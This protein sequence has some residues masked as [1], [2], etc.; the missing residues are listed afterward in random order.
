VKHFKITTCRGEKIFGD[1]GITFLG[2]TDSS[3]LVKTSTYELSLGQWTSDRVSIDGVRILVSTKCS[4][5]DR[6]ERNKYEMNEDVV[7]PTRE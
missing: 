2:V 4:K 1:R 6:I 7:F 3:R 5:R